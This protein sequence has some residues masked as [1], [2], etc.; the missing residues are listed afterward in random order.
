M[1]HVRLQIIVTRRNS[2]E[3]WILVWNEQTD[4]IDRDRVYCLKNT[5][6]LETSLDAAPHSANGKF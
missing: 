6:V 1:R 4:R 2:R 3:R 5:D